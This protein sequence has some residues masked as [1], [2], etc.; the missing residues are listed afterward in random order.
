MGIPFVTT[1]GSNGR[2]P[3]PRLALRPEEA[4]EALACSRDYFDEHIS[5]ELKWVRRGRLKLV[6]V[7]ELE[8]WLAAS[9]ARTLERT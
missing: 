4:A 3:V 9:S 1:P 2:R 6:A 5:P 8:R 7:A